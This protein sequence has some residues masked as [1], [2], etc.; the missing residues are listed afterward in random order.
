MFLKSITLSIFI[1][2]ASLFHNN[3]KPNNNSQVEY[4]CSQ[5]SRE[6]DE[7]VDSY[8]VINKSIEEVKRVPC[9]ADFIEAAVKEAVSS[10]GKKLN[11]E[12]QKN[13]YNSMIS[14]SPQEA[15]NFMTCDESFPEYVNDVIECYG[16]E[17]IVKISELYLAVQKILYTLEPSIG[18]PYTFLKNAKI[19][20]LIKIIY[21]YIQN[22]QEDFDAVFGTDF[23]EDV[24][25][26]LSRYTTADQANKNG[27]I[28]FLLEIKG[29][30]SQL[31][32]KYKPKGSSAL[33]AAGYAVKLKNIFN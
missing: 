20:V 5:E 27:V 22:K 9:Y 14:M 17:E 16:K 18:Y 1:L 11:S 21:S 12:E 13:L 4:S 29:L 26:F 25:G 10:N 7:F 15:I 23:V 8:M 6:F 3:V 30:Q 28:N 31:P 32:E 19:S 24:L 2:T 33:S